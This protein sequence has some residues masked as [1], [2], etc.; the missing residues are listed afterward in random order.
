VQYRLLRLRPGTESAKMA[1]TAVLGWLRDLQM[2]ELAEKLL[3]IASELVAN[4]V[5]HAHTILEISMT[6]DSERVTLGVRD[7][8]E[9]FPL[10][11]RPDIAGSRA[12]IGAPSL[13]ESGRGLAIVKGLADAWGVE[14]LGGGKR[15]WAQVAVPKRSP[16]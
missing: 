16:P 3:L 6:A 13:T 11:D 14:E 8:D 7:E 15:I 10:P 5:L 1:R 2:E 12:E 4:A 9:R